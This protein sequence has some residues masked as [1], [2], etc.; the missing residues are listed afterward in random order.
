MLKFGNTLNGEQIS[1][2]HKECPGLKA[3][4][5]LKIV[6]AQSLFKKI[7]LQES[8]L[9]AVL[10]LDLCTTT[11]LNFFLFSFLAFVLT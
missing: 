8:A 9:R 6:N 4:F 7:S 5:R 10:D 3:H 11:G 2:E 1:D